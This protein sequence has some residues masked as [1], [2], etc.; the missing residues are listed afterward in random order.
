[1]SFSAILRRSASKF[2]PFAT[3]IVGSQ[4]NFHSSAALLS[5]IKPNSLSA[6]FI[7]SATY[8]AS[9]HFCSNITTSDVKLVDVL[10]SE[11]KVAEESE[12]VD[13][14][15]E[16]PSGFPFKI[17]DNAGEQT[18]TLTREFEGETITVEVSM[19]SLITGEEDEE[20]DD[21]NDDEEEKR[22][23]SS[24]PLLVTVAK[25][26]G[27]SLEFDCTAYP[28]EISINSLSLKYP[29]NEDQLAYEGP[30]FL[31]LDENLQKA[32]HKYLE[33]RGIKPSTTNF[34]HEYMVEKD[35]KEYV[36]WLKDVKNFVE[37]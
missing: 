19:P 35:N 27:P 16:A 36:R 12:D 7:R 15:I 8:S 23:D 9:R 33:I 1:M 37:A 30:D 2:A 20:D 28:D 3:R 18:V 24:V 10:Q 25:K 29:E 26:K 34:L 22:S 6:Q 31:D 32:F 21:D 4:K 5:A 11:I 17:E 14:A 13:K